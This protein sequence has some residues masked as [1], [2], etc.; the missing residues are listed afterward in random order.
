M[1]HFTNRWTGSKTELAAFLLGSAVGVPTLI[2]F[3]Q[4]ATWKEWSAYSALLM[5]FFLLFY[6]I[7]PVPAKSVPTGVAF[8][9]IGNAE[10]Q[11][12]LWRRPHET[13]LVYRA[14]RACSHKLCVITGSSGAGKSVL[15]REL[16]APQF[17]DW[18]VVILDHYE[19]IRVELPNHLTR[20]FGTSAT[21]ATT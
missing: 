10:Q 1:P 14:L 2:G 3:V 5:L 9:G 4:Y 18:H 11:S 13:D 20:L 21:S 16:V 7:R 19:G 15:L 8:P 17:S 12:S 6:R